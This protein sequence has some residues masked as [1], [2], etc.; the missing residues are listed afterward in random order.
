VEKSSIHTK[1][2][3]KRSNDGKKIIF[4]KC[5]SSSKLNL[6]IKCCSWTWFLAVDFQLTLIAPLIMYFVVKYDKKTI[7]CLCLAVVGI[8]LFK[9]NYLKNLGIRPSL[10]EE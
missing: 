5:K 6:H 9:I 1:L 4:A 7:K 8:A 2:S 3:R 10:V